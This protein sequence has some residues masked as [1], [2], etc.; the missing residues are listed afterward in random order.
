MLARF[1]VSIGVSGKANTCV[2]QWGEYLVVVGKTADGPNSGGLLAQSHTRGY[3]VKLSDFTQPGDFETETTEDE[4][5]VTQAPQVHDDDVDPFA[6]ISG[7]NIY[8][9]DSAGTT[10]YKRSLPA[11]TEVASLVLPATPRMA[12]VVGSYIYVCFEDL[13]SAGELTVQRISLAD[14]TLDS[15]EFAGGDQFGGVMGMDADATHLFV[16]GENGFYRLKLADLSND[17]PES[18]GESIWDTQTGM[19]M[20]SGALIYFVGVDFIN[21]LHLDDL[22][23]ELE[24]SDSVVLNMDDCQAAAFFNILSNAGNINIDQ[25]IH[26]HIDRMK[27]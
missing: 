19:P 20:I 21:R 1:N 14:F 8:V 12:K 10:L 11:F 5:S 7:N 13:P 27:L 24:D 26:Q 17:T 16:G 15:A 18:D 9:F 2:C 22:T 6:V 4:S 23:R 3:L 25:L